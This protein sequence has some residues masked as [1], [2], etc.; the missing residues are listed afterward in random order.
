MHL[1]IAALVLALVCVSQARADEDFTHKLTPAEFQSAGLSKLT[2]AELAQ[3]DALIHAHEQGV[4][5]TATAQT[6][7]QVT[8]KVT[9]QVTAQ[10]TATVRAQ[11]QAED[12]KE[13]EKKAASVGFMDRL[14]VML[15]P[16]TEVSYTTLDAHILPPFDGWD[17]GTVITLDNG[18][19]WKV[20][21]NSSDF[22]RKITAPLHVRIF[23]GSMEG[24]FFMEVDGGGRPKV[25]YL[26]TSPL[27]VPAPTPPPPAQP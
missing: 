16:G 19:R 10:V 20:V 9:Q 26:S 1:R 23:P 7:Q 24:A 14:K 6:A 3:L 13:E 2:P 12:H 21:D 17:K 18:Q 22:R 11:T 8:V 27:A 15:K 25:K 5:A 4:V